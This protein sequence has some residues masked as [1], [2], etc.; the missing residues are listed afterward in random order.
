[1]PV[2]GAGGEVRAALEL[3][4]ANPR[5]EMATARAALVVATGSLSRQ[6]ATLRI[7]SAKP[8]D[9]LWICAAG[10]T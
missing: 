6:L 3:V 10:V 1:M 8:G 7:D 4:V 5:A 9:P 2:F